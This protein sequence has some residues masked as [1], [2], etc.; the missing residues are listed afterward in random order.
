[1][2]VALVIVIVIAAVVLAAVAFTLIRRAAA[3]REIEHERVSGEAFAHRDQADANVARARDLGREAEEHRS[4]AARHA[5]AADEHALAAQEHAERA[6][7][8]EQE[9]KT[10]GKAAAFHDEQAADR[11]ERLAG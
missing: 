11:E 2:S 3:E 5:A 7:K 6:T 8:L 1:M 10:A 9:V 4:E